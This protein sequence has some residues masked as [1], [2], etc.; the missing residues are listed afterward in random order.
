[1]QKA[2]SM[3][4]KHSD[5]LDSVADG[6]IPNSKSTDLI[7][8]SK[9]DQP[10]SGENAKSFTGNASSFKTFRNSFQRKWEK[11]SFYP[12]VKFMSWQISL[13]KCFGRS[14]R[15][16][17]KRISQSSAEVFSFSNFLSKANS[18]VK[19]FLNHRSAV[20]HIYLIIL[21]FHF[22]PAGDYQ[23]YTRRWFMLALF[24]FYSASNAMQWIQFSIIANVIQ[25]YVKS[26]GQV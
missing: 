3:D 7:K 15:N 10:P 4:L 14:Y 6:Y 18:F 22:L 2:E 25:K 20:S 26:K 5:T 23:V 16:C 24:V 17:F 13:G 11:I 8:P 9:L 12:F 21:C 1:M 19:L